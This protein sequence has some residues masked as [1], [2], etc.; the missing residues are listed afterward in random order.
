MGAVLCSHDVVTRG[1]LYGVPIWTCT[2]CADQFIPAGMNF[3]DVVT[4]LWNT[5][6]ET[7]SIDP[8]EITIVYKTK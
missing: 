5:G 4:Y 7:F 1:E 3:E 6:T 2:E 8:R